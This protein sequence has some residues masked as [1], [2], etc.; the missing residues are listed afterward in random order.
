MHRHLANF[1]K[2]EMCIAQDLHFV[3][4]CDLNMALE[5]R[6]GVLDSYCML[7]VETSTCCNTHA[8][9]LVF[10]LLSRLIIV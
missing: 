8:A 5:V 3:N 9:L 1:S 7:N 4:A 2:F 6:N 10:F